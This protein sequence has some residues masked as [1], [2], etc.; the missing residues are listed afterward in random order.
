[1]GGG[2]AGNNGLKSIHAHL[3]DPGYVRPSGSVSASRPRR[4][5]GTDHVLGRAAR[6]EREA[7]EVA[8][9]VAADALE[10]IAD[11]GAEAAMNRFNAEDRV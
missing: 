1:M 8:V 9:E 4:R 11:Q 10:L 6:A 3:H 2:T 7:L 5:S